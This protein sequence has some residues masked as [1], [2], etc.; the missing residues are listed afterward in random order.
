MR[1]LG[2]ILAVTAVV[3][4][5]APAEEGVSAN[6]PATENATAPPDPLAWDLGGSPLDSPGPFWSMTSEATDKFHAERKQPVEEW[7]A[8]RYRAPSLFVGETD[9]II[10]TAWTTGGLVVNATFELEVSDH[11]LPL[12]E[13]VQV[14][15]LTSETLEMR[16][17]VRAVKPGVATFSVLAAVEDTPPTVSPIGTM[18]LF[19]E[20]RP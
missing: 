11:L 3:G 19:I 9:T 16:W 18:E 1:A 10:A 8:D 14:A 12:G 5:A 7:P 13:L 2:L 20:E 4:C 17:W 6:V 15:T